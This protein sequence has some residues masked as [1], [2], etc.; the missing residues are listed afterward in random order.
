[1]HLVVD[2]MAEFDHVDDADGRRLVEPV[3]CSSVPDVGL[4][5][6]WKIGLVGVLVDLVELCSV[7]NRGRELQSEVLSGPA[8]DGLVDLSQVHTGRNSQRVEDNVHRSSVVEER[9]VFLPDDFGHYTLVSMTS[10]HLVADGDLPLLGYIDLRHL[11]Y[12]VGEFISDLDLVLF[13]LLPRLRFL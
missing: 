3:S 4:S 6:S 8:E 11:H 1:M 9:H 2:H 5:E 13:T 7:E 12:A 10:G